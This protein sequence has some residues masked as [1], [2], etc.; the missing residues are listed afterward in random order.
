MENNHRLIIKIINKIS[1]E[2]KEFLEK[3]F[4]M[5]LEVAF[6]NLTLEEL[7]QLAQDYNVNA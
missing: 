5:K 3:S 2:D 6:S 4:N 1:E 7:N